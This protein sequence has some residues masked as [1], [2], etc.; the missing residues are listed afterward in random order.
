M[1]NRRDSFLTRPAF[2]ALAFGLGL[3]LL[4]PPLLAIPDAAGGAVLWIYL[5]AAWAGLI[6]V[7]LARALARPPAPLPRERP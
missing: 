7:L 4:C 6:A 1:G 5:F 2:A 3:A